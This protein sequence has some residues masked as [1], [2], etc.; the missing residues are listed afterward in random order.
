MRQPSVFVRSAALSNYAEVAAW[1]GLDPGAMLRRVGIDL[2]A[3]TDPDVRIPTESVV[4]LLEMSAAQSGCESFGLRMAET[5]RLSDLGALS[6]LITH[7]PTMREAL[8]SVVEHRGL[9]NPSLVIAV[10]EGAGVVVVREELLVTGR[11]A[12]RQSYELGIGVLFRM[13]RAVLGARWR[14]H[15]VNFAHGPPT[16]PTHHRRLFGAACEFDSAFYGLTCASADLQAPNP[17]ADP[18]LARFAADYVRTLPNAAPGSV[19]EDVRKAIVLLL[20]DGQASIGQV[21]AR[22][23]LAERTLQ[24]RL[25]AEG[26]DFSCLLNDIRRELAARYAANATLPLS[27]VAG[28]VG[29]SRQ[30][31]FSRWFAGEFGMTPTAWRRRGGD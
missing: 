17:S 22:L 8:M 23:G 12:M 3:L 18:A 28:M 27:H 25:L 7:Q 24:R 30:S 2:R 29:Y 14:P 10:E 5:R 13:F 26:V 6:L 21:A 31:S 15:S 20:A 9:L 11:G 19:D 16:D 1:A 4:D